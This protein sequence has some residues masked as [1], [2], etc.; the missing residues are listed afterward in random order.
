MTMSPPV[1]DPD[2]PPPARFA[3]DR[4]TWRET[5]HLLLNLP[6]AIVGFVYALLVVSVGVGL[7]VTVIGLPVL[8]GGLAG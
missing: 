8:V 6:E 1:P 2:R 7:S 3:L 5:A 4:W